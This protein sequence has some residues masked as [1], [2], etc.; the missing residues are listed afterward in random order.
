[1][2]PRENSIFFLFFIF[3]IFLFLVFFSVTFKTRE[4]SRALLSAYP[5][6]FQNLFFTFL[7]HPAAWIQVHLSC[8][9]REPDAVL[10][11]SFVFHALVTGAFLFE[12]RVGGRTHFIR[13]PLQSGRGLVWFVFW[14]LNTVVSCILS[15]FLILEKRVN[16]VPVTESWQE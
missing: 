12:S 6:P 8:Y 14:F 15:Y 16:L 10:E 13:F 2:K 3:K 5:S 9:G 1:M 7:R 4:N 11:I